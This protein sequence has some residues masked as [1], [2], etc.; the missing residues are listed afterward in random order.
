VY[1]LTDKRVVFVFGKGGVGKSTISAALG[2]AAAQQQGRKVLIAEMNGAESMSTLFGTPAVGY[3]GRPLRGRL[4]GMTISPGA[5]TEE[6]LVRMLR[7][8]LLYETVFRNR[9][10]AP[11]MDGVLG[12]SDLISMGKVLDLEWTRDDGSFGPEAQGPHRWDLVIVDGPATGHGLSMLRSPQ[13]MMDLAKVGPLFQNARDIRDLVADRSRFAVVLVT[14]AEDMPVSECLQAVEALGSDVDVDIAGIVVNSVPPPLFED[15]EAEA[16]WSD[17]RE[18][19]VLLGGRAARAINDGERTL[20]ER[21]R[22]E[23]QVARL[24]AAVDVPVFE[25]PRLPTRDLATAEIEILAGALG[26]TS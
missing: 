22:A 9:F 25:I 6:Y 19:G 14:L 12:L 11:L 10:I 18:A 26:A 16:L 2:L 23:A 8:R 15:K 17:I 13:S 1:G 7:F 3:G 21:R 20:A 4:H 5:A 24:R